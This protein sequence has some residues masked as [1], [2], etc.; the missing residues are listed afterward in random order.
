MNGF[1]RAGLYVFRKKHRSVLMILLFFVMT[2][3]LLSCVS[4]FA[5]IQ[6]AIE[7]T[8]QRT[9]ARLIISGGTFSA[10]QQE[11]IARLDGVKTVNATASYMARYLHP[12]DAPLHT[13]SLGG[14][15]VSGYE[16]CGILRGNSSSSLD[17]YFQDGKFTIVEGRHTTEADQYAALIHQSFARENGLKPGDYVLLEAADDAGTGAAQLKIV[18]LFDQNEAQ[19]GG[20]LMSHQLYENMAFTDLGAFHQIMTGVQS[21]IREKLTVSVQNP[22]TLDAIV[23][24]IRN[25]ASAQIAEQ[26]VFEKEDALYRQ[27]IAPLE[28]GKGLMIALVWGIGGVSL[29]ALTLLLALNVRGRAH[30]TAVLRTMGIPCRGILGQMI[31]ENL[32]LFL[33]CLPLAL[34][35]AM[36]SLTLLRRRLATGADGLIPL[37]ITAFQSIFAAVAVLLVIIAAT[38]L[39]FLPTLRQNPKNQLLQTE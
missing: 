33:S 36:A 20:L 24:T 11:A 35:G 38:T 17:A 14:A 27:T 8:K 4:L 31:L 22:S 25:C 3:T 9:D 26:W 30:E 13:V 15:T 6:T 28:Q 29:A 39:A 32:L 37:G 19:P 10:K 34:V 12:T 2:S 18:G 21:T 7:Q 5:G 16:H 23:E 1:M